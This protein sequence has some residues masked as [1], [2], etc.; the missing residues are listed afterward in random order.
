MKSLLSIVVFLSITVLACKTENL[1]LL[2]K[3]QYYFEYNILNTDSIVTLKQTIAYRPHQIDGG[4]STII[5]LYLLNP[6]FALQ[7]HKLDLEKD[8]DIV[9][10]N[11]DIESVWNWEEEKYSLK[12]NFEIKDW[13]ADQITIAENITVYDFRRKQNYSFKGVRTFSKEKKGLHNE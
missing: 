7:K 2:Q 5:T 9:K 4:S 10:C 1:L 12:G 8:S 6:T 3:K 13:K 11:Y